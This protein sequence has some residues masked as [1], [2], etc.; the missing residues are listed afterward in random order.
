MIK[1]LILFL[2]LTLT[3][4]AQV[5]S[6]DFDGVDDKIN[7]G[8]I[9]P[10]NGFTLIAYIK[11]TGSNFLSFEN[12]ICSRN[13]GVDTAKFCIDGDN[14]TDD[15]RVYMKIGGSFHIWTTTDYA[16]SANT[17]ECVA[18]TYDEATDI[19]VYKD[20]E[21]VSVSRTL[22]A[23]F[24]Q[25]P[26]DN[27]DA[28]I[29]GDDRESANAEF[30]GL[31]S[32]VSIYDRALSQSEVRRACKCMNPGLSGLLGQ[33]LLNETN[34]KDTSGNGKD[35]SCTDCPATSTDAPPISWCG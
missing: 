34:Y 15:F 16:H 28:F 1:T 12:W 30:D 5:G 14:S 10:T 25:I 33:W 26:T 7:I 27:E 2:L 21:S 24:P 4:Y 23:G 32:N 35:G 19:K 3:S 11:T 22:G 17:W 13:T 20:G 6:L 9:D 31:I 18:A 8:D 29:G